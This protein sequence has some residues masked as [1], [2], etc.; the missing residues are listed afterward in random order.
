MNQAVATNQNL[1]GPAA[2]QGSKMPPIINNSTNIVGGG[3][4]GGSG[5]GV[6]M[7]M[8]NEEPILLRL[9]YGNLKAV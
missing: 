6:S 8:R 9:Q 5:S 3:G 1:V 2:S 7:G 4:S